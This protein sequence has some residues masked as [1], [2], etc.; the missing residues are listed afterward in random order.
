MVIT[1]VLCGLA[2]RD[3]RGRRGEKQ[4]GS[5]KGTKAQ[6]RGL[7]KGRLLP[8]HPGPEPGSRCGR[9]YSGT[10]A[11]GR[12][13]VGL[14]RGWSRYLCAF[15]PLCE[16]L[17]PSFFS[18]ISAP[19]REPFLPAGLVCADS[20]LLRAVYPERLHGSRRARKDEV[21]GMADLRGFDFGRSL[22]SRKEHGFCGCR[23]GYGGARLG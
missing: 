5:H 16:T 15:V 17:C 9:R 2:A 11:Q 21:L 23:W 6:K 19:L 8:R 3:A 18:A 1:S 20:G 13:D 12:G 10:P 4:E 7:P 22:R 14:A